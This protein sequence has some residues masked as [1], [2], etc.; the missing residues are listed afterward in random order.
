[1]A[2][3]EAARAR[4]ERQTQDELRERDAA[5]QTKNADLDDLEERLSSR[6]KT[7]E[8]QLNDK[9]KLLEVTSVEM[10]DMRAQ[11][12]V[13]EEQ[14]KESENAKTWLENALHEERN[15]QNQALIVAESRQPA[16]LGDDGQDAESGETDG[17]DNIRTE[18]EELLKARDKLIN[19]LMGE[20]KEKKAALAK[21]EI[22]V[23]QGIERRG[24]WK[25]RL[26]KIGIRLKD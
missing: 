7:L 22:E 25:H 2:E 14:L 20:L 9:Q 17:L 26:S 1:V 4:V 13:L 12:S 19:D 10:G 15:K 21:H 5:L 3:L 6:L 16:V 24:V 11:M 23:W 18:R 8:R